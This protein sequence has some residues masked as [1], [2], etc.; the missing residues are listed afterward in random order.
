MNTLAPIALFVYNRLANTQQTI[1]H[2]K[3]NS[4]AAES[5]LYVFSDG[6]KDDESWKMV[7]QLRDYLHTITG[8]KKIHLIE[9][10]ENIYIEQN[11]TD[12]IQEVF[13]HHDTVI[14]LED[15]ICTS[16]IFLTYMNDALKKYQNEKRVMHIAGFTNLDLKDKGDTYFTPHMTGWG[17]ATWKDRWACFHRYTNKEEALEG[18]TTSDLKAIEYDGNFQ[19]LQ[20]L[21]RQPIPWDICWELCIYKQKGLCLHPSHTLIK[22][23]GIKNGTHFNT[24]R[25]FG[26]YEYDRDFRVTP[27]NLS[28]IPIEKDQEI[29]AEYKQA[30][31]DHG[32]RY[33]LIG[34]LVRFCYL[35]IH[36][37]KNKKLY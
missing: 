3:N 13:K 21:Y 6:G 24:Q 18:L 33:N 9:R 15:D 36:P 5:E 29:E 25:I 26:W 2:L 27:I 35:L 23:I 7:N 32:M 30:L 14:V 34:K 4:L 37:K 10:K 28:D 17:W 8:F 11:I 20:S 12:G 16:P 19:C 1:E 22:N 31:K